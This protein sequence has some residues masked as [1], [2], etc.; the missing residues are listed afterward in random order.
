MGLKEQLRRLRNGP[1]IEAH[2][3]QLQQLQ[4]AV[5]G[6]TAAVERLETQ[7]DSITDSVRSQLREVTDDLGDRIGLLSARLEAQADVR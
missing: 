3:E 7:A 4:V 5:A 6:L 2:G 1:T